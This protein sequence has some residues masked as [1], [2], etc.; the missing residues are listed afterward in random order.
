[1]DVTRATGIDLD[2]IMELQAA[3]QPERGGMLSASFANREND[4]S[5][6]VDCRTMQ[7]SHHWL[8]YDQYAGD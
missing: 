2:G 6:A 4:A 7:W 5:H 1:V 3:N 8:P